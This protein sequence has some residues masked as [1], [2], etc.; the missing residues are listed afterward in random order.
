MDGPSGR[1]DPLIKTDRE[2]VLIAPAGRYTL[3]VS[4]PGFQPQQRQVTIQ[5]NDLLVLVPVRA[6]IQV[7]LEPERSP[8]EP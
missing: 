7:V 6:V 8:N 4:Q 1:I 2:E 3:H 5:A